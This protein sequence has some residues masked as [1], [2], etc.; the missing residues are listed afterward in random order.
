M[1][2]ARV[3]AAWIVVLIAIALWNELEH[4]IRPRAVPARLQ[5]LRIVAVEA[6]LLVLLAAL[7]FASLGSGAGWLVFLL[8]GLLL[9]LPA[10]LRTRA[11]TGDPIYWAPLAGRVVR[12]V[13]AGAGAGVVLTR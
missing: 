13:L 10:A 12:T 11:A 7:W 6:G 8:V 9:E 2:F 5:S 4:R 3:V 1:A